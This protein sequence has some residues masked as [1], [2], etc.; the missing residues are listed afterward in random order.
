MGRIEQFLYQNV[1]PNG[2]NYESGM[3]LSTVY[4]KGAEYPYSMSTNQLPLYVGKSIDSVTTTISNAV[5]GGDNAIS[6]DCADL[7][8]RI[9]CNLEQRLGTINSKITRAGEKFIDG[10]LDCLENW[11]YSLMAMFGVELLTAHLETLAAAVGATSSFLSEKINNIR[12]LVTKEMLENIFF[13]ENLD[14][15]ILGQREKLEVLEEMLFTGWHPTKNRRFT[16]AEKDALRILKGE[17]ENRLRILVNTPKRNITSFSTAVQYELKNI[18]EQIRAAFKSGSGGIRGAIGTLSG[19]FLAAMTSAIANLRG[20][21]VALGRVTPY[22]ALPLVLATL[23]ILTS[24]LN[25]KCQE[26]TTTVRDAEQIERFNAANDY[27]NQM[28]DAIKSGCCDLDP[29]NCNGA[30]GDADGGGDASSGSGGSHGGGSSC[31]QGVGLTLLMGNKYIP[32][33]YDNINSNYM[34]M[35]NEPTP[36]VN[37][38]KDNC[39]PEF[40]CL[41][42]GLN[43]IPSEGNRWAGCKENVTTSSGISIPSHKCA[44]GWKPELSS[45]PCNVGDILDEA[46]GGILS[47]VRTIPGIIDGVIGTGGGIGI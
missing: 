33:Y 38:F 16:N 29:N 45:D 36:G 46:L 31:T 15:Q 13:N 25:Q 11:I 17:I 1:I 32:T 23:G 39:P 27:Y 40:N 24:C 35:N 30:S 19:I 9:Y 3:L 10:A 18:R 44:C 42:C 22:V 6:K 43:T 12:A 20:I 47:V 34:N 8:N 28:E 37:G 5:G 4:F 7:F 2:L 21:L 14:R 26:W 41:T